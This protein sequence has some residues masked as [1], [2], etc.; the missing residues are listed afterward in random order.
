MSL[1]TNKAERH[2]GYETQDRIMILI[3][4]VTPSQPASAMSRGATRSF[5]S[6]TVSASENG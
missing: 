5:T 3:F 1:L 6:V 4:T 2:D